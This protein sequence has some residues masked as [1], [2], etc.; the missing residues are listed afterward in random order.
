MFPCS[1]PIPKNVGLGEQSNQAL[2]SI[3]IK[4]HYIAGAMFKQSPQFA[5]MLRGSSG[6]GGGRR[7]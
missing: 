3:M 2:Q 7:A 1:I 4:T 5:V 6:E